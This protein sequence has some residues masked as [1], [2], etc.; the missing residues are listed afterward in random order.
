[1]RYKKFS[2]MLFSKNSV[3]S[4]TGR[5]SKSEDHYTTTIRAWYPEH[6]L[7]SRELLSYGQK[8]NLE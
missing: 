2:D 8:E 6:N 1:M 3:A 4:R 5:M 7:V